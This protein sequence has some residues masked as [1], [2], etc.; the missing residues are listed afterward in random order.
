MSDETEP[1][2]PSSVQLHTER[3]T[4]RL[5]LENADEH[6]IAATYARVHQALDA[7]P[8]PAVAMGPW[9][10][11]RSRVDARRDRMIVEGELIWAEALPVEHT[12]PTRASGG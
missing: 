6:G 8:M 5:D 2:S 3:R 9:R 10:H 1:P 11:V 7:V 12:G 4:L